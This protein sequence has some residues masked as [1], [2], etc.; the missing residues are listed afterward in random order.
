MSLSVYNKVEVGRLSL[1][2]PNDK[3]RSHLDSMHLQGFSSEQELY[4]L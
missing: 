4:T 2:S 1:L 3:F